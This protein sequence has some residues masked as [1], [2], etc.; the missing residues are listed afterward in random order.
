MWG[1][2]DS[3]FSAVKMKIFFF[4]LLFKVRDLILQNKRTLNY[5]L[6]I[7]NI[8]DILAVSGQNQNVASDVTKIRNKSQ[9]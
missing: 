8:K 5:F 4:F 7:G 6:G 2:S 9:Q 1:L 3:L